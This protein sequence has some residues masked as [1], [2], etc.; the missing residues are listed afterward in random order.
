MTRKTLQYKLSVHLRIDMPNIF[1]KIPQGSF[2]GASRAALA[3]EISDAAASAEQ[4][5]AD[6]A[7]RFLCWVLIEEVETGSWSCGG[8]D[9]T[10]QFLPCVA[11]VYV[12]AGV[13]DGA[14]RSRYVE[15]MHTA[16]KR[17]LPAG[18]TRRLETSVVLHDVADGAWGASGVVWT[19]ADFARA[20][21]YAHSP[22]TMRG[23]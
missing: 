23:A 10:T 1:V 20:A 18:E 4:I 15:L 13:L 16:F 9:V 19:L 5:P 14:A 2:A 21:G 12:P 11:L 6:P 7:K 22:H 8:I 3:A 17:A